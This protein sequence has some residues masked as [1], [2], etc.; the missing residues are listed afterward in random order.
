MN[1]NPLTFVRNLFREAALEG[2]AEACEIAAGGEL[3]A[4]LSDRLAA[5]VAARGDAP[6]LPAPAP[7]P[8][9]RQKSR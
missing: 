6:A 2:I 5:L 3:P 1:L 7:P 8:A 9:G 4:D